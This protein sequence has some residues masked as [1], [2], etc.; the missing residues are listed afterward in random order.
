MLL[1][2]AKEV[3]RL[4]SNVTDTEVTDLI[5]SAIYDLRRVGIIVPDEVT[6]S[7]MGA[8]DPLLERAILL[9][10]KA[11]YGYND[12]SEK[13]RAAYEHLQIALSLSQEYIT[14][15]DDE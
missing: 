14:E 2:K 4:S 13:F 11:N 12:D 5:Y 15:A 10:C 9:Y 3:L 8:V 7:Y 6:P 1:T